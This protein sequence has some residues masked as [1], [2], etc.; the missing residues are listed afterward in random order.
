MLHDHGMDR[1]ITQQLPE[2][3]SAVVQPAGDLGDYLIQ[4][5]ATLSG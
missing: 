3:G 4:Q 5:D 1:G 2:L